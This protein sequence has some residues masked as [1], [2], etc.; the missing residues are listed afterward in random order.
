MAFVQH[1]QPGTL[2]M[3]TARSPGPRLTDLTPPQTLPSRKAGFVISANGK[4]CKEKLDLFHPDATSR[5]FPRHN[6]NNGEKTPLR[7]VDYPFFG[8]SNAQNPLIS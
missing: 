4:N 6:P 3:H 5:Q 2:P 1:Q 8:P 7:P